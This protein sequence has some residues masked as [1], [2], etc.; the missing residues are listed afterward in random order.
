[1]KQP[2]HI[3]QHL[4]TVQP[5]AES[6]P[7]TS[8]SDEQPSEDLAAFS[9]NAIEY[10]FRVFHRRW[11]HKWQVIFSDSAARDVWLVDLHRLGVT[12]GNIRMG[13]EAC[14]SLAWPP[15]PSEFAELC[16]PDD[17]L[18]TAQEAYQA[19]THG[20]YP[21]DVVYEAARL[22]GQYE[23]RHWSD[24]QARRE[25]MP[26]YERV[27]AEW[28]TGAR[29]PRP[30]VDGLL[31]HSAPPRGVSPQQWADQLTAQHGRTPAQHLA[32]LKSMVGPPPPPKRPRPIPADIEPL[33]DEEFYRRRDEQ[34]AAIEAASRR[35]A[36]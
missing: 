3:S 24:T 7:A 16:L 20:R 33:N 29:F 11:A 8:F 13:I 34:L 22:V 14:A 28:R 19:A 30:V 27:C 21:H 23:L 35:G 26:T 5:N 1:M 18:P 12:D 36:I 2:Q 15:S 32:D 31:E 6:A 9:A 25:F 17:G 4:A 10:L